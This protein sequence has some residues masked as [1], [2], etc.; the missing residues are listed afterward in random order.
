MPNSAQACR[1]VTSLPIYWFVILEQAIEQGDLRAAANAERQLW[2]LGVNV[3]FR[4]ARK[5][6]TNAKPTAAATKGVSSLTP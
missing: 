4:L 5:E 2:Q 1:E 6:S 3:S